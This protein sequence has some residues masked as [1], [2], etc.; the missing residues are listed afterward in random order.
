MNVESFIDIFT[1]FCGLTPRQYFTSHVSL[2]MYDTV[3]NS[4]CPYLCLLPGLFK[5]WDPSLI[6]SPTTPNQTISGY[7]EP[8]NQQHTRESW[9][10]S[11]KEQED[12]PTTT[13]GWGKGLICLSLAPQPLLSETSWAQG[14]TEAKLCP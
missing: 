3:Y 12:C 1:V 14:M 5:G 13:H 8:R 4:W 7:A 10:A 6:T 9:L 11:C 2:F